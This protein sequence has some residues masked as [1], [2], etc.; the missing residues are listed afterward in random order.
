MEIRLNIDDDFIKNLKDKLNESKISTITTDA[1][2]ILNWAADEAKNG[3]V[4]LST[5]KEGENVKQLAMP[6]LD[7]IPKPQ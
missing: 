4:I 7:K 1:L 6:S 3:R 2:T 5:D